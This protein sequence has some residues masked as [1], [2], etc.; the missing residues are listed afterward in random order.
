MGKSSRDHGDIAWAA[1]FNAPAVFFL[2]AFILVPVAGTVVTGF[3]RDITFLPVKFIGLE[4]LVRVSG[5]REF[6]QSAAFTLSFAAVTVPLELFTG[7]MLA[8]LLDRKF[9]GRDLVRAAV[10]IPW[11]IPSAVSA[12]VWE[13]IYNYSY[14]LANT[15]LAW[16]GLSS[17]PVNWLGTGAGAFWAIVIADVWKTAPFTA[18]IFLAGLQ[19]L[20]QDIYLQARVDRAG[21]FKRF[22]LITLPLIKPVFIV[23]LLFR[24]IDC[25]RIFDLVYVLTHGGPGGTTDA[26][27]LYAY[28]NFLGGDFGFGSAVSVILFA[29]SLALAA[30]YLKAGKFG[31]GIK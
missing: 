20:P 4:N 13:L 16:S 22:F 31:E 12:R 25:L 24:T 6:G 29:I 10:L 28:K 7:L 21:V 3:F 11:A 23:A 14:G 19:A 9:P 2:A 26:V 1:A 27:S 5:G 30:V 17:S 18:I 15:L 8:L